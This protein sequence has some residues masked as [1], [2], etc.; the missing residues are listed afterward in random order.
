MYDWLL[1]LHLLSAMV[2]VGA[3]VLLSGL[4]MLALRSPDTAAPARFLSALGTIGPRVLAPA[5]VAT[6]GFGVWLVLNS[7]AWG[8]GQLWVL[9]ALGL[10]VAAVLIGAAYQARRALEGERAAERGDH[11]EVRTQLVRWTWGY[12][13]I[14]AAL[15]ITAWDMVFKPGL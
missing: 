4:A 15:V 2:W 8:F 9:L 10:V 11:G 3:G 7:P 13:A 1:F 5:S 12:W 6:L 14:V